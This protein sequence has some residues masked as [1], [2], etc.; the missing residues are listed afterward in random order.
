MRQQRRNLVTSSFNVADVPGMFL[1]LDG[2]AITGYS[3]LDPLTTWNDTSGNGRNAATT[4][5]GVVSKYIRTATLPGGGDA[6]MAWFN[7]GDSGGSE[8]GGAFPQDTIDDTGVGWTFYAWLR[9]FA[10]TDQVLWQDDTGGAP[11]LLWASTGKIGWRD[12]IT[13]H[14]IAPVSTGYHSAIWVFS[15]APNVGACEVFLDGASVGSETWN[16]QNPLVTNYIL[17][18]NQVSNLN[19]DAWVAEFIGWRGAHEAPIRQAVRNALV[20]KWGWG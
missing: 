2:Q 9:S 11:Q 16:W 18:A 8:M 12:A 14:E 19:L 10:T 7:P 13:T 20:A 3:Q 5:S 6:G 4:G 17:G 15:G 1:R